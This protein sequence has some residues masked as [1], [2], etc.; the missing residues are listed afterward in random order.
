MGF[1]GW[2]NQ[3][4]GK[5]GTCGAL[6]RR[7]GLVRTLPCGW[8][9]AAARSNVLA[10]ANDVTPCRGRAGFGWEASARHAQRAGK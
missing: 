7:L 9:H 1:G 5:T 4:E 6:P 2:A 8:Q 3:T 10:V